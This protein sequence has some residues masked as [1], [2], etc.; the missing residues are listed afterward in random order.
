MC[1]AIA[2]GLLLSS[3]ANAADPVDYKLDV[4]PVLKQRC[5]A[6]HGALK[7]EAGLRLDSAIFIRRPRQIF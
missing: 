1:G 7:Q 6:C 3:V 5:Y 4:Q 2:V